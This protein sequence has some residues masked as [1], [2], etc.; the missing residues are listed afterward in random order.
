MSL[1]TPNIPRQSSTM[2]L[3]V[4]KDDDTHLY[5]NPLCPQNLKHNLLDFST[6]L[7]QL[8]QKKRPKEKGSKIQAMVS[9]LRKQKRE[10]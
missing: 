9:K 1:K 6:A 7:N 8:S 5:Y 2:G 4:I 3:K 10:S